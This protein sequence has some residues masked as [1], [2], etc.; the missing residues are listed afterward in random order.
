MNTMPTRHISVS[1]VAFDGYPI[2]LA[3][4]EMAKLGVTLVEPAYIKGYMDFGEDDFS[5]AA[6]AMMRR[7][8]SDH[9]LSSI[10]ISAHMDNGDP[11]AKDM[12]ARRI[13]FAA[14]IGARFAIT[15]STTIDRRS[16]LEHT[17]AA[18]LPLA[19]QLGVT[20]ALENPANGTTNLMRD[21]KEGA[22]VVAAF[23]SPFLRLNYDTANALTCKEG[24][25]RPEADID[26]ALP[27]VC[28]VHLKDVVR[29]ESLWRYVAIG[30]G[31]LDYSV[32]LAK[33]KPHPD[34]PLTLELPL[35]LKR[36]FHADPE[37]DAELPSIDKITMAIRSSR[38]CVA[39]A[40]GGLKEI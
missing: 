26:D 4:S 30:E 11:D 39:D 27:Q 5:D 20:I 13:R 22:A 32:L 31:E 29:R 12:L 7:K 10:A 14:A 8:L 9:G 18:N 24:N 2:D 35:R 6:A 23:N 1:T 36:R 21:G 33:L 28:H 40:L 15:N 3:F 38:N 17:L 34:I 19:Q 25:V 37:R 16:S